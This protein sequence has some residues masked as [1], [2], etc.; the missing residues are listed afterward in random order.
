MR[1]ILIDTTKK[2]GTNENKTSCFILFWMCATPYLHLLSMHLYGLL[3]DGNELLHFRFVIWFCTTNLKILNS[4]YGISFSGFENINNFPC[5]CFQSTMQITW[6]YA[7]HSKDNI[8]V[9][10]IDFWEL[11]LASS[12]SVHDFMLFV[13]FHF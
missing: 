3:M 5:W 6:S 8:V 4:K 2:G 13:L 11:L 10:A 9:V 7:F 12:A 1:Y